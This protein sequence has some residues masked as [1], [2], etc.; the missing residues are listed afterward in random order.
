[1]GNMPLDFWKKSSKEEKAVAQTR[2]LMKYVRREWGEF[3]PY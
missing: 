1:M 3:T 2:I